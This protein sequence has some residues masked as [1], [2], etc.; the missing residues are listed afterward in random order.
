MY[1]VRSLPGYLSIK[2]ENTTMSTCKT[3]YSFC[4]SVTAGSGSP[5]HIRRLTEFGPKPGGGADT[6][7]LCG[8]KVCWDIEV[9]ITDPLL[10]HCCQECAELYRIMKAQCNKTG[11]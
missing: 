4:E 3:R 10:E 11:V 6:D 5:W 9:K 2:K 7:A 8:R 1:G